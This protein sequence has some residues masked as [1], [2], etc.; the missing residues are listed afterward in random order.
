MDLL[1]G[2]YIRYVLAVTGSDFIL[3]GYPNNFDDVSFSEEEWL[4]LERISR[5]SRRGQ[6]RN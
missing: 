5:A 2:K 3:K 1:L 4:E 6:K